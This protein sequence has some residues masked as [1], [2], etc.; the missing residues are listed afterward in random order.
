MNKER[1]MATEYDKGRIRN[2]RKIKEMRIP[3]SEGRESPA[4]RKAY[5]LIEQLHNRNKA[6]NIWTC[7]SRVVRKRPGECV[8]KE[9]TRA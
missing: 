3:E 5:R 2:N 8:C 4:P 1:K 9:E 7:K 6:S